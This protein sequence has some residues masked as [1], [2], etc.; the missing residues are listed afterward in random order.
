M[1]KHAQLCNEIALQLLTKRVKAYR[2]GIGTAPEALLKASFQMCI[3][4][5]GSWKK[6]LWGA[7]CIAKINAFDAFKDAAGAVPVPL[8]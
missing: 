4:S 1:Q 2:I 8:W 6:V 7:C 3:K 5:D